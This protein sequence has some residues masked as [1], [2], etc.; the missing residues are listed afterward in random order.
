MIRIPLA[1]VPNQTL[2]VVLA[3]QVCGITLRQ[4]GPNMYF[5]LIVNGQS[6]VRT[7]LAQNNQRLLL[8]AGY[9]GV[10]GDFTFHDTRGDTKPEFT[11]LN[12]R[13]I[14]LYLEAAD[15]PT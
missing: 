11:G 9:R 6:V 3:N 12:T 4:N 5:D 14:L 8:D 13:Y 15:L 10:V 1:A 2:S 7:R